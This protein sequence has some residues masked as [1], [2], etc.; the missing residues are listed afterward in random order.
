MAKNFLNIVEPGAAKLVIEIERLIKMRT[1][2]SGILAVSPS[3]ENK[4]R[5]QKEANHIQ[6]FWENRQVASL[7][8]ERIIQ[9][10]IAEVY[11]LVSQSS[12]LEKWL[13]PRASGDIYP[14]GIFVLS[15]GKRRKVTGEILD[16]I[17]EKELRL[18]WEEEC[19][20]ESLVSFNFKRLHK[21]T[22]LRLTHELYGNAITSQ[23]WSSGLINQWIF[24]LDNLCSVAENGEDLRSRKVKDDGWSWLA[25]DF[26]RRRK[27]IS[28]Q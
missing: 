15:W 11:A 2:Y 18:I 26:Y 12:G 1:R 25:G 6:P 21:A 4:T 24:F 13:A 16:V 23:E 14:G 8:Y 7:D 10:D 19:G 20:V 27:R 17:P 22:Y 3:T 5:E 28:S 9:K